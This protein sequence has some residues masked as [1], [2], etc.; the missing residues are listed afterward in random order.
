MKVIE[1]KDLRIG[2]TLK[3]PIFHE[4][5]NLL[6]S[7]GQCLTEK[8]VKAMNKAGIENVIELTEEED[9]ELLT[10]KTQKIPVDVEKIELFEPLKK[11]IHDEN[12]TVLLAK[13]RV[14][15][16][17]HLN[18]LKRRNIFTVYEHLEGKKYEYH[19]FQAEVTNYLVEEFD[20]IVKDEP[21]L[22]V[23]PEGTPFKDI[24][25]L[26]KIKRTKIEKEKITRKKN[27]SVKRVEE[28]FNRVAKGDS[29]PIRVASDS[30]SD[31]IDC[32]VDD[33]NLIMAMTIL[34][35]TNEYLIEHSVNVC[36]LSIALGTILG[37]GFEQLK[38]LGTV[39]ILHDIGMSKIPKSILEKPRKLTK[40]E[41]RKVQ[42]HPVYGADLLQWVEGVSD[43]ARFA[44]YQSH[45][46]EAGTGYPKGR[47]GPLIHDFAK[48]I[49]VADVYHAL[50]SKRSYR[51]AFLPYQAVEKIVMLG[52]KRIL[53]PKIIKNF[54]QI[55]SLFPIGSWVQ[56][57]SKEVG[58]VEAC[59]GKNYDRPL[60]MVYFDKNFEKVRQPY[61]V[62]LNLRPNLSVIQAIDP[63]MLIMDK[64]RFAREEEAKT[65]L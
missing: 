7:R 26:N 21:Q 12:G 63:K 54:L 38:D 56:L 35:G 58:K 20:K 50:C 27:D 59:G 28:I 65:F 31:I 29:L 34:G 2:T 5:G 55:I 32:I 19:N 52:H 53:E 60:V 8:H 48:I 61:L 42:R 15:N 23:K 57:S 40:D 9:W 36:T 16:H 41:I 17:Y 51:D 44:I 64:S 4:T 6:L 3:N 25:N 46:R 18:I 62:D 22:R 1:I 47:K 14:F 37:F 39:G 10:N 45:E 13:G 24:V 43:Y 33:P 11:S 30:V 49:A